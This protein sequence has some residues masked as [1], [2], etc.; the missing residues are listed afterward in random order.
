MKVRK[1]HKVKNRVRTPSSLEDHGSVSSMNEAEYVTM[2]DVCAQGFNGGLSVQKGVSVHII[3][4][5]PNGW[6]YCKI[7]EEEGWV[8]SSYIERREKKIDHFKGANP[9][10]SKPVAAPRPAVARTPIP[11]PA[12]PRAGVPKPAGAK[13]GVKRPGVPK[14]GGAENRKPGGG[15]PVPAK[16]DAAG[17]DYVAISDYLDNDNLNIS[18]K[19][20]AQ[21]KVL[22]KSDSGWWYVQ[23]SGAE[24]WAPSTYLSEKP[25]PE[26]P[27]HPTKVNVPQVTVP[28]MAS[29]P[30]GNRPPPARPSPPARPR[31][32]PSGHRKGGPPIPSRGKK[33]S[34]PRNKT[35]GSAEN[36]LRLTPTVALKQA[37]STGNLLRPSSG[38]YFYVIADYSDDMNDTLDIKKGERLEVTKRDEGGWWLAKIGNRTGWVPSSYLE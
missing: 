5:S 22:E 34:L 20:G 6:W 32:I 10:G 7:G 13:P 15:R 17:F 33:P 16:R 25:K 3:E 1:S 31:N 38:Q 23:S 19:E 18:L 21:V 35:S 11:K 9:G 28:H 26:R 37:N 8:P 14:P 36:L 29:R 4:K 2:S 12:V 24:G 30:Q 27:K